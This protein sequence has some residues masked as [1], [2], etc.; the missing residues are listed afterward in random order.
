MTVRTVRTVLHDNHSGEAAWEGQMMT[1]AVPEAVF[2]AINGRSVVFESS[3]IDAIWN[4]NALP[5]LDDAM[6][7][8]GTFECWVS[9]EPSR[10]E[11]ATYPWRNFHFR[12]DITV[13]VQTWTIRDDRGQT[14]PAFVVS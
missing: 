3:F 11:L 4:D 6:A 1:I 14:A 13:D 8:D 9:T 10:A 12:G 5:L 2:Q 7:V